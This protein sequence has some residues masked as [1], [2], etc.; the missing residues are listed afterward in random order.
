MYA[1]ISIEDLEI[2]KKYRNE[3]KSV[4]SKLDMI[5]YIQKNDWTKGYASYLHLVFDVYKTYTLTDVKFPSTVK[6]CETKQR[7]LKLISLNLCTQQ[8]W[9]LTFDYLYVFDTIITNN[10]KR[11]VAS[12]LDYHYVN[13]DKLNDTVLISG[14]ISDFLIIFTYFYI[15]KL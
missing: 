6:S 8:E 1:E 3:L 7:E 15:N 11:F 10:H 12:N 2:F 14:D 9:K 5:R 4:K 13:L